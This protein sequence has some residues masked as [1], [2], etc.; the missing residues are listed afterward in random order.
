MNLWLRPLVRH[1]AKA[2]AVSFARADMALEGRR[3]TP[4]FNRNLFLSSQ[5]CLC[6]CWPLSLVKLGSH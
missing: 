5:L 6:H 3:P 2:E 4:C 1:I